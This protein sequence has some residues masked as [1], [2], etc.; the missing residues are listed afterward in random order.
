MEHPDNNTNWDELLS[1][2]EDLEQGA[3]PASAADSE[4]ALRLRLAQEMR[5]RLRES[6]EDQRFPAEAGWQRFQKALAKEAE[7]E[8]GR[9]GGRLRKLYW[10]GAAA[11]AVLLAVAGVY[12]YQQ[13]EKSPATAPVL[14]NQ[15]P[16]DGVLLKSSGGQTVILGDSARQLQLP[17]GATISASDEEIVYTPAAA[18]TATI[19]TLVVPRGNQVRIMLAD[20]SVVTVNAASKLIFPSAFN[21]Q[22]RE[23]QLE[24]EAYFEVKGDAANPFVVRAGGMNVAVLGTEF[25]INTYSGNIY[26]TLAKGKVKT[27]AGGGALVLSP[28]EQAAWDRNTAALQKNKVTLYGVTAWKDNQIYFEDASLADIAHTLGREYDYDIRFEDEALRQRSFTLDMPRPA[29]LQE[30]LDQLKRTT[31]DIRFRIQGRTIYLF[32]E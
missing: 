25:N 18:A 2:L 30:V 17:N 1:K 6:G 28:G 9:R 19:D 12:Y 20:G 11:A 32:R 7:A 23:V 10:A 26:A 16:A 21:G 31:G 13:Q 29:S 4:E 22:S 27:E 3:D 5:R 15:K 14:A 24:G 8:Y